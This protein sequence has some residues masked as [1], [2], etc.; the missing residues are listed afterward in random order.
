VDQQQDSGQSISKGTEGRLI[1][2][3]P[4]EEMSNSFYYENKYC[5]YEYNPQ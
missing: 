3:A 5:G 2:K 4:L 1:H